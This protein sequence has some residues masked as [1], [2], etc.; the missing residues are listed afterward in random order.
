MAGAVFELAKTGRSSCAT[1]GAAIAQGNPRVG[2]EIWR[3]GRRCMTYQTP[4]AFLSRLALSVAQDGRCKCKLSSTS[5]SSG[6][7]CVSFSVGGAKGEAPTTQ[8]CLLSKAAAF[9]LEV[10]QGGGVSFK[11]SELKG[12]A[13]LT[14]Q[15]KQQVIKMLGKGENKAGAKKRPA[16]STEAASAKRRRS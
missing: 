13:N 12:F 5:I 16:S 6:D 9:L 10:L 11:P 15:Q 14:S 8:L 7:L 3:V 1:T 2:F 4:K